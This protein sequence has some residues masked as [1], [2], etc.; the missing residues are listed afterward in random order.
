MSTI[1]IEKACVECSS[2]AIQ[3]NAFAQW[4][5]TSQAFD[6]LDFDPGEGNGAWCVACD[7]YVVTEDRPVE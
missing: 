5:E 2:S 3:Y 1:Q 7:K 4:D 6:L